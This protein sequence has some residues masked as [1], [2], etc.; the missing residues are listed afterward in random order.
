[1]NEWTTSVGG[2]SIA[3]DGA[4]L[5]A[6]SIVGG[7][8]MLT[9]FLQEATGE[10]GEATSGTI[11]ARLIDVTPAGVEK[12][13]FY[14]ELPYIAGIDPAKSVYTYKIPTP[15]EVLKGDH[16]R[17]EISTLHSQYSTTMRFY[18]GDATYPAGIT[19]DT[20][21]RAGSGNAT[22][23]LPKPKPRVLPSHLPAT[24]VGSSYLLAIL[25]LGMA[26][27]LGRALAKRRV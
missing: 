1:V 19:L 9:A 14:G 20:F 21:A 15:F 4:P 27:I 22:P 26:V 2:M 17:V 16:L 24:G 6:N 3:F 12:E 23:V 11:N 10:A 25:M 13:I 7:N 18:Y 8:L 5:S